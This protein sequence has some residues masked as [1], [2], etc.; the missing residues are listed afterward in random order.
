MSH[1]LAQRLL[2][3]IDTPQDGPALRVGLAQALLADDPQGART[4]ALAATTQDPNY[5]A[6]WKVLG[7]ACQSSNDL[8]AARSA[9]QQGMVVA[10][11]RGDLQAAKEMQVFLKRIS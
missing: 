10:E 1:T 2:Q 9:W 3:L 4:H 7:K 11:A 5:T 8:A 6:A